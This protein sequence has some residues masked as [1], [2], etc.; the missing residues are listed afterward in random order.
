MDTAVSKQPGDIWV[1]PMTGDR[2]PRPLIHTKANEWGG[3]FSPDGKWISYV[4]NESGQDQIYLAPFDRSGGQRQVSTSGSHTAAAWRN[5]GRELA[6][7]ARDGTVRV[8][9]LTPASNGIDIAPEELLFK[10][11]REAPIDVSPDLSRFLVAHAEPA[12]VA[13]LALVTGW[14]AKRE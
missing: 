1:L 3:T 12:P 7:V 6:Y 13:P 10:I 5:D 2:V 14:Q 4:S 9:K 8:V 11:D